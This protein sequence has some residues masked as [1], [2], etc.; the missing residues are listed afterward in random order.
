VTV[1]PDVIF[2]RWRIAVFVDGCFWH[3]C[4]LHGSTP[5]SNTEYWMPK[6]Q[7]NRDRDCEAVQALAAAGWRSVRVWEHD[8]PERAVELVVQ[9]MGLRETYTPWCKQGGVVEAP[10]SASDIRR[11]FFEVVA[12]R[13]SNEIAY[14]DLLTELLA[15]GWTIRGATTKRQQDAI[16]GALNG[17]PQIKK[18][19]PG[20]FAPSAS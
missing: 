11:G 3:G 12:S 8:P 17:A 2:T 20:V 19:R 5:R 9:A 1:R 16:Y 10:A 15:R 18:V 13:P 7:R 6:L 14:R 4:P